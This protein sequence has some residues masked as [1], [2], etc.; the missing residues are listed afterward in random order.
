MLKEMVLIK[1]DD[2]VSRRDDRRDDRGHDDGRDDRR[3]ED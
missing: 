2:Y 1:T 3:N